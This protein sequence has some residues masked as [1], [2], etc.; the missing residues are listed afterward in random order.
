MVQSDVTVSVELPADARREPVGALARRLRLLWVLDE[1]REG[2]MTGTRAA[3]VAGL[4][5]DD[6][7]GEAAVR[8]IDAID[9]DL[10]DF[11]HELGISS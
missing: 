9:Y 4:S 6:L 8:G 3:E 7:L 11:R 5:L 1:V 2:R 10:D